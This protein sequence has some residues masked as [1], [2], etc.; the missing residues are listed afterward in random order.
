MY[1]N[2]PELNRDDKKIILRRYYENLL[3]GKL[4]IVGLNDDRGF[5]FQRSCLLYLKDALES[6]KYDIDVFDAFSMLFNK[7]RHIDYYLDNNV[8]LQEMEQIQKYGTIS[9][10]KHALGESHLGKML[11]YFAGNLL[12]SLYEDRKNKDTFRISSSIQ[13]STKPIII[14]SS[15]INDIMYELCI[16]PFSAKRYYTKEKEAYDYA[17]DRTK[18]TKRIECMAKIL[19][20]H[21][22]NFEKLLS[23]NNGSKIMALG[24]YLYTTGKDFDLPFHDFILEYNDKLEELCKNYRINYVDLRFIENTMYQSILQT[25]FKGVAKLISDRIIVSLAETINTKSIKPDKNFL[26]TDNRVEGILQN[27]IDY[28]L[29][30]EMQDPQMYTRK[31]EELEREEKVLKKVIKDS[32]TS[33]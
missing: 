5:N 29:N 1:S 6:D 14:Y 19:D 10:I 24:A 32:K 31:K 26:H 13:N 4:L 28:R 3:D 9:E 15:G 20:G 22:N 8:S 27:M 12:L 11:G 2:K 30:L 25:Y 33:Q 23:L 18:G 17:L 7:I 21:K 16:D